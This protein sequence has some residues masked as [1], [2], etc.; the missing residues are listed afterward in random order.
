VSQISSLGARRTGRR[1]L[2]KGAGALAIAGA[3]SPMVFSIR[4]AGAQDS[5]TVTMWGNHP[6]WAEPMQALVDAFQAAVPGI[7]VDFSASP[8]DQYGAK[9][10]TAIQGGETSDILG[11]QEGDIIVFDIEKRELNVEISEDE[12]KKR[13]ASWTPPPP[14]YTSGVYAKYAKLVSSASEGAITR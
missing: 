2:L 6:E 11:M 10:Q 12:M 8:G 5:V 9:L 13:L 4:S 7:E 1:E 14:N 3:M